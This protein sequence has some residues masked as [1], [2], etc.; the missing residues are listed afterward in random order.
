[1]STEAR[2]GA[3]VKMS[4][5][6]R[7]AR[8]SVATVSR[9]LNNNDKVDPQ[10]V[11]RVIAAA[12]KLGYTPN[13]LA[14]N[15]RLQ[16]TNLW[17][18]II[19]DIENTFFTSVARGVEDVAR[20][21]G[22]SVAL[23]NADEDE[24]KESQYIDLAATQ[25]AAG[26]ILSP[27]SA[28]VPVERLTAKSIPLV[29]IDRSLDTPVDFVTTDSRGG[30]RAATEYLLDQ[31]W[32]RPACIT[33]P[34]SAETATLRRLGY[35]DALRDAGIRTK[36]IV[37][38]PFHVE[39]GREAAAELLDRPSPPDAFF[40]ANETLSMGVL[41]ELRARGLKQV[42]DVGIIS[43]DDV[44]WAR[45]IDPPI[46]VVAQPAYQIGT[47]AAELLV[48]RINGS[49]RGPVQRIVFDTELVLR[50]RSS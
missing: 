6:A 23:C 11:E 8:T 42:E 5:V 38:K 32:R 43:F 39:G 14:R 13:P 44:P 18:L 20:Q 41:E 28:H 12:A 40:V 9:V 50:G 31:G 15:L 22:F 36:R 34:K 17:L 16:R 10:L 3:L 26:V 30:A 48:K 24:K 4:D 46:P 29:A 49:L 35:E 19:S 1:M 45:V 21:H 25:L 47:T 7:E 2:P 37:H 33:G 27:H